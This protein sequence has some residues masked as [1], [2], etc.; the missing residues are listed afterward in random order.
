MIH[1][2]LP[3]GVRSGPDADGGNRRPLGD[4]LGQSSGNPFQHHGEHP[5]FLQG[6]GLPDQA[7]GVLQPPARH[8]VAAGGVHRL[9]GQTNVPH[10]RNLGGKEGFYHL[11]PFRPSLQF[12]R[13]RPPFP[14]QTGGVAQGV[15]PTYVKTHPRHV[16]H[17]QGPGAGPGNRRRVTHHVVDGHRVGGLKAQ[18]HVGQRIA[19]QDHVHPGPVRRL[20]AGVVVGGHHCQ[21][22]GGAVVPPLAGAYFGD[23]RRAAIPSR[24]GLRIGHH[25]LLLSPPV[26]LGDA[27][28]P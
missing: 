21:R 8:L 11:R 19:H 25:P 15:L 28:R 23:G 2:H 4:D 16:P 20:R 7:P 13:L 10:H 26:R 17:H 27:L 3:V 18:H 9:R 5:R 6:P 24:N 12:H 14:N 22:R 1:Q